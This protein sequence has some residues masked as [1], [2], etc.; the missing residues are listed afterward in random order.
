MNKENAQSRYA[1]KCNFVS[2]KFTPA[3]AN[4]YNAMME[5]T[6][7]NDMPVGT[8]IKNLLAID[9]FQKGLI[10]EQDMV[11]QLAAMIRKK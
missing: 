1:K 6:I 10:E 11:N 9:L 5:Y 8:Y 3:T 4:L 2:L 7:A